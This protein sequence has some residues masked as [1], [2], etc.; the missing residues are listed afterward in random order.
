[1][2]IQGF[3]QLILFSFIYLFS[4]N[5]NCQTIKTLKRNV[6]L[7]TRLVDLSRVEEDLGTDS[8]IYLSEIFPDASLGQMGV[9]NG[10]VLQKINKN[11]IAS[12]ADLRPALSGIKEGD[13]L[14]VL[15]FEEGKKKT[16]RGVAVGRAKE[17]HVNADV[18]YGAVNYENN[19]LRSIL[20]L[21]KAIEK[22]P[23]VFFIQGYTCQSIEMRPNNPAK[24][25]IDHWIKEG[26]AV[27]LV[28]KPG[29]GDSESK[30]HCME[31]DFDQELFAFSKAYEALQKN[32][33]IDAK[34]IFLFG[35]SMGGI[36]A[37]LLAKK[38]SPSGI[39]V[40]GIVGKN[41]Y[42]YM[43]DI[44][45]EQPLVMGGTQEEIEENKKYYLPFVKDLLVHKKTNTELLK[46]STYGK[47]LK[48]DGLSE[49]LSQ[50]YYL[51]R[52]YK[53]WQSLADIDVPQ[54][55]A[56][57]K[58]PVLVLHGEYDIQAI[59]P[60]YGE[61]IVTNVNQHHGNATFQLIPKT[62]HAFLKFDS[63]E[64]LQTVMN[65]GTYGSTFATHFNTEIANQSTTWMKRHSKNR[66]KGKKD[67]YN[68]K[69]ATIDK[70]ITELYQTISG[71]KGQ[72]RDWDFLKYIFHPEAKFIFS[73]KRKDGSF[74]AQYVS[75]DDYINSSGKYM[76]EKGFYE[77]ELHR[78]TE[79]FGQ[80]AHVFTTYECFHSK[81]EKEP[82]M[83]GINSVQL[84]YTGE[85]W[86][87]MS[88]YF[89]QESEDNPIPS[90][91]L[92]NQK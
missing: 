61:M 78:V 57:V 59:H 60:K 10:V 11:A 36:I 15:V 64:A 35:H 87:V 16:Y 23:V 65:D 4:I 37:P 2:Q 66:S 20:Y 46:N 52:H 29:M 70:T 82:F 80:I 50:G 75:M 69:L 7:G 40:Y 42:D 89:T 85:R 90:K 27:F 31:I 77:N 83:R 19:L 56:N 24:Q 12:L 33:A 51:H 44:Y 58:S 79:Q 25:L 84:M 34:N 5:G 26:Y 8:G 38:H 28:E 68:K 45:V 73:G 41:W 47:R 49:T 92:P 72:E 76:L 62:E 81:K 18:Q 32:Q 48:E 53:Y 17:Q 71:P 1:M 14:E 54:A 39:M 9:P 21:P 13:D 6:F 30:I 67:I 43:I 63:R 3:K 86:Q 91:Y 22:P 88:I 74:G 55:W